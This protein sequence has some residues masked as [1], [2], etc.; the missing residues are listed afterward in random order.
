MRAY[1]QITDGLYKAL[2]NLEN[3]NK[4]TL[5]DI[6]QVDLNKKTIFPLAHLIVNNASPQDRIIVFNISI[7]FIDVVDINT[8][9]NRGFLS[10]DNLQDVHN[11][12]LGNATLITKQARRGSLFDERIQLLNVP[13]CEPFQDRFENALAGWA[14]TLDLAIQDNETDIC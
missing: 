10:N 4:V 8:D 1:Y 3:I 13:E 12:Q 14:L 11:T 7:L 2:N 5:G 6:S 9:E